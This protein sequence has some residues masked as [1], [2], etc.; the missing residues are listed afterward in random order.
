MKVTLKDIRGLKENLQDTIM[1]LSQNP[2]S[3]FEELNRL[4]NMDF[5]LSMIFL[6]HSLEKESTAIML[7]ETDDRDVIEALGSFNTRRVQERVGTGGSASCVENLSDLANDMVRQIDDIL[8]GMRLGRNPMLMKNICEKFMM[9]SEFL[10]EIATLK[11]DADKL[12]QWKNE[13][14][15]NACM[16]ASLMGRTKSEKKS[17]AARENGKKGGRPRKYEVTENVSKK[18]EVP[19]KSKKVTAVTTNSKV[20]PQK[21]CSAVERRIIQPSGKLAK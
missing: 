10:K 1:C 14:I 19:S 8:A 15:S 3:N 9:A 20:Q 11:G 18:S 4:R 7:N 2:A 17:A 5:K 16:A 6:C 13:E 21:A 12:S